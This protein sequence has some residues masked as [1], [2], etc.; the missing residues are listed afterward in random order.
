MDRLTLAG[1]ALFELGED[2]FSAGPQVGLAWRVREPDT[3]RVDLGPVGWSP[4][5]GMGELRIDRLSLAPGVWGA[6]ECSK[7][8]LGGVE[9]FT[10]TE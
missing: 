3:E 7:K 2:L 9:G 5:I 8:F 10:A 6:C 4:A 1:A